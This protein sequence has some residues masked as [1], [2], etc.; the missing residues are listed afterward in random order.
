M[1]YL[2]ELQQ[3]CLLPL[4]LSA[5]EDVLLVVHIHGEVLV[6]ALLDRVGSGGDGPHF[7]KLDKGKERLLVLTLSSK[8]ISTPF[9]MKQ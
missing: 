3:V 5:P 2:L 1:Q 6:L 8:G 9:S 7:V 4:H